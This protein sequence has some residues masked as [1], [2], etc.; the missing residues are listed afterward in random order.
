MKKM[1]L[2]FLFSNLLIHSA[3]ALSD[4]SDD[5]Y[6]ACSVV[7]TTSEAALTMRYDGMSIDETNAQLEDLAEGFRHISG[8]SIT[9]MVSEAYQRPY[10]R[11][12]SDQRLEAADFGNVYYNGC[13]RI[14]E[15]QK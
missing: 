10:R 1:G 8:T 4:L 2:A 7:G 12:A 5:E 6:R 14:R 11:S 9:V 15:L 13:I 3:S